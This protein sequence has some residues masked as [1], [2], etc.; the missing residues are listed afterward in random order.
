M[1]L[2]LKLVLSIVLLHPRR[3]RKAERNFLKAISR[4]LRMKRKR[5]KS[6][7]IRLILILKVTINF[8]AKSRERDKANKRGGRND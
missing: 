7:F 4:G 2:K 6:M 8:R 1:I 3:L 5:L